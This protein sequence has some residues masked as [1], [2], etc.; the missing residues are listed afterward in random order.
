MLLLYGALYGALYEKNR[1]R[2]DDQIRSEPTN[3]A[4]AA[5][6]EHTGKTARGRARIV[7]VVSLCFTV[8]VL[9][10][11]KYGIFCWEMCVLGLQ[12]TGYVPQQGNGKYKMPGGGGAYPSDRS[13]SFLCED[14]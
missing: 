11:D 14:I 2:A 13:Y 10:T 1:T 8:G 5:P 3:A 12:P 9:N 6:D 4:A 7:G